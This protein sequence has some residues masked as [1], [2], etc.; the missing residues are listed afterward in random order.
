MQLFAKPKPTDHLEPS[1]TFN[2]EL[3][4][5]IINGGE[6]LIIFAKKVYLR[7]LIRF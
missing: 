6:L 3:F 5:K 2:M 7:C 1:E 4:T